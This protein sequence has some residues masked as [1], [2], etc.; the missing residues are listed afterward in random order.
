[1]GSG[2]AARQGDGFA[3]PVQQAF[4]MGHALAQFGDLPPQG[5]DVLLQSG[6]SLVELFALDDQF[7]TELVALGGQFPALFRQFGVDAFC[8]IQP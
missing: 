8:S 7:G 1:M 3:Q 4:Q 6:K 5:R 2:G